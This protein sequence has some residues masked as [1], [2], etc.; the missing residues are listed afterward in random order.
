M[1]VLVTNGGPHS[2]ETWAI[3]TAQVIAPIDENLQKT[4]GAR[5]LAALKLQAAIADAL[6]SHHANVQHTE[7]SHLSRKGDAHL[8]WELGADDCIDAAVSAIQSAA[9]G[10]DWESHFREPQIVEI[11][12]HEVHVHFRTA[13]QIERQWHCDRR[14]GKA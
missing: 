3:A 10:T 14:D 5:H 13:Q 7:R 4:D 8:A 11:I 2:P 9:T 1:Q 12:K 6:V